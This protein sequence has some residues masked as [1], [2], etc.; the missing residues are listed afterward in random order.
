[1]IE[2][3]LKCLLGQFS[4]SSKNENG[5]PQVSGLGTPRSMSDGMRLRGVR[6]FELGTTKKNKRLLCSLHSHSLAREPPDG[7][8]A[9]RHPLRCEHASLHIVERSA[10]RGDLEPGGVFDSASG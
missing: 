4:P 10:E 2:L 5:I 8:V 7:D 6:R 3:S 9:V 1:M